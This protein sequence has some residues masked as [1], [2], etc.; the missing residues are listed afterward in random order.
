M[1]EDKKIVSITE[2]CFALELDE[3]D[4]VLLLELY[5]VRYWARQSPL[6]AW[7]GKKDGEPT[8]PFLCG[9]PV[10]HFLCLN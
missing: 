3:E 6:G 9:K 10:F 5:F 4:G 2:D 8:S 7:L 1:K